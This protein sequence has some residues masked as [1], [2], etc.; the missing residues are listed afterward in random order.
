MVLSVLLYGSLI[1]VGVLLVVACF[2]TIV[3]AA[4]LQ[5][6]RKVVGK[7]VRGRSRSLSGDGKVYTS[8]P[9]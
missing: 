7:S 5:Q 6:N 8:V 1:V 3:M 9:V 2:R 4:E